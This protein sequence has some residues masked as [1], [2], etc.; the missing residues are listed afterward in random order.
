MQPPGVLDKQ[1]HLDRKIKKAHSYRLKRRTHEVMNIITAYFPGQNPNLKILDVGTADGIMLSA[2]KNRFPHSLCFGFEYGMDLIKTNKD[3][4]LKMI[5]GDARLLPFQSGTFHLLIACSIIEHLEDAPGFIKESH[6]VLKKNGILI[7]T[8][9]VP[10]WEKIL[11][12]TGHLDNDQHHQ[13]YNLKQLEEIFKK[14][15]I[16]I[17]KSKKFMMSPIGFPF[18]LFFERIM[19]LLHLTFTLGNQIIVGQS[20]G[21][22][23]R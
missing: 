7:V 8:T 20:P 15:N 5:C 2:I 4:R 9:P 13:T 16:K 21:E 17:L 10:F 6:R 12:K 11:T 18:E 23:T 1:Y 22:G 3:K 19:N 14:N